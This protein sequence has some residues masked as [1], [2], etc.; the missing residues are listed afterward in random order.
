MVL[1]VELLDVRDVNEIDESVPYITLVVEVYGKVEEV[2]LVRILVVD[3]LHEVL[4][5]VLVGDVAYHQCGSAVCF[6]LQ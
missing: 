3:I 2:I 1:L 4:L 6:N 5:R